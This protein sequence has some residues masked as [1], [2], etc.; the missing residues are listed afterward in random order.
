MLSRQY[1]FEIIV[2]QLGLK[3]LSTEQQ[4]EVIAGLQNNILSA[5]NLAILER[6]TEAE[7]EELLKLADGASEVEMDKFLRSKITDLDD[8]M[9]RT[10]LATVEEFKSLRK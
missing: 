5:V 4:G 6:L 2:A 7:R 1:L 3:E 10:A 9:K 8:L